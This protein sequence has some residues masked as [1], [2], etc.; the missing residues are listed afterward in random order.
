MPLTKVNFKRVKDL[1][2]RPDYHKTPIRKP[3]EESLQFFSR[4]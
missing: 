3:G 1:N 2:I 4:K